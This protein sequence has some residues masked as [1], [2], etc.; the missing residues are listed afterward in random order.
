MRYSIAEIVSTV[1]EKRDGRPSRCHFLIRM[2]MSLDTSL[3]K[4]RERLCT[5][6]G[7]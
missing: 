3:K 6:C 4:R 1:R 2:W 7:Y 5:K